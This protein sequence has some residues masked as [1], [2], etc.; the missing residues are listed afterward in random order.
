MS[1]PS[2]LW[3]VSHPPCHGSDAIQLSIWRAFPFQV[4]PEILIRTRM[5]Y[6][7]P[8]LEATPGGNQ[9]L[10]QYSSG[11]SS[12]GTSR[13]CTSAWSGSSASSTPLMAAASRAWP[14]STSSS[15]LSESTTA[16]R[17]SPC[18]SPA[19][20]ADLEAIP[21]LRGPLVEKLLPRNVDG[22][23][24]RVSFEAGLDE[25]FFFAAE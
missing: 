15:T 6:D 17:E 22:S 10:S 1:V 5:V 11:T 4:C 24:L 2:L 16:F 14:S 8:F 7:R 19:C 9:S 23:G 3:P 25:R 18:T 21:L 20:P 12:S 13:V